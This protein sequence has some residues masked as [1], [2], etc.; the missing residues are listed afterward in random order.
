MGGGGGG[1]AKG[2]EVNKEVR[3]AERIS[4]GSGVNKWESGVNR[5]GE[6]ET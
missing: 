2:G 4:G 6:N 5:W 3:G 1:G